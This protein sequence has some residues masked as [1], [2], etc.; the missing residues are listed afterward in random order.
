MFRQFCAESGNILKALQ[1]TRPLS[2]KRLDLA[3]FGN[4]AG[5]SDHI[6]NDQGRSNVNAVVD[7][8]FGIMEKV[9]F[10]PDLHFFERLPYPG[11]NTLSTISAIRFA[12]YIDTHG[13]ILSESISD[14][15]GQL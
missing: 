14:F 13:D 4:P 1:V 7:H 3:N 8:F 6:V 11:Q 15:F 2:N 9:D 10:C 12:Q 5:N